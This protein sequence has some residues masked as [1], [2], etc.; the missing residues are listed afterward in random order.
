M[1]EW[2]T[3]ITDVATQEPAALVSVLA[4]EGSAPRGAG[5][6]MLVSADRLF[7]TIGGGQ[8]EH[9]AIEQARAILDLPP[10]HWRVQD[11][12]LGPLL[13][14]CC[15]G[16]V[17]LLIEHVD[18]ASLDWL[19]DAAEERVL[20]STLTAGGINRHVSAQAAPTALS[21]RGDRPREGMVFAEIIGQRRRPLYL[22]GAGHVGQAIARHTQPLP[23]R[24]AWFDTR[25]LFETIDGVAI[26]PEDAI[27]QCVA[28]APDDAAMLILTH[29]HGLDYH[30]TRA[31]LA[32]GPIAFVGLIGSQTKRARFHSRLERDGLSEAARARLTCP[33]GVAGVTGKE[34]DVIAIAALAQLLQLERP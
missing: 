31:T 17:R 3:W 11:Y 8:L 7:G 12:P 1:S 21:A 6:R 14:Q 16:R 2:L 24:L 32:R 33:I 34:P 5:T 26:V 9:R 18:P 19:T 28:E 10:G 13:G 29:D 22:F 15:G 20:V 23:F 4:S 30:L 25:P 27:T